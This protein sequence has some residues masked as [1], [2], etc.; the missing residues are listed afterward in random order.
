MRQ[1]ILLT[2]MLFLFSISTQAQEQETV[3]RYEADTTTVSNLV[4]LESTDEV[5]FGV[6]FIDQSG[7]PHF[8]YADVVIYRPGDSITITNI[9]GVEFVYTLR[10]R[11]YIAVISRLD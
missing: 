1:F 9:N 7:R 5:F 3:Q 10:K 6:N 8:H 2:A 11:P 4:I